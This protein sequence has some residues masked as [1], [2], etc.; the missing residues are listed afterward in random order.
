MQVLVTGGAGFIGSHLVEALLQRGDKVHVLD[1]LSTGKW[2]YLDGLPLEWIQ[3]DIEDWPTV[4]RAVQGCDLI[5]HLAALV[6]VP[7]SVAEPQLNHSVNVTGTFQIFEAARQAGLKR[8]VYASSAAVYGDA[9]VLPSTE[10]ISPRPITP[11]GLAKY[12]NEQY[13]AVYNHTYGTE[14][15][16]LRY[17]NVYGPRQDPGSPYSGVLTLF[18]QAVMTGK[19]VTVHGD[20]QQTRDF[21][22][23]MDVVSANLAAADVPWRAGMPAVFNVGSGKQTSLQ[24]ILEKIKLSYPLP[25]TYGPERAGD[26]RHSV[27]EVAL[28]KQWL[29]FVPEVALTTGLQKTVDWFGSFLKK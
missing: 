3:G 29:N 14:F 2:E 16:G 1:N 13:A 9:P 15:I 24:Q 10:S 22:Y 18:C 12:L 7:R 21:V 23:V 28:A 20:G 5:F 17:F 6:S 26:I 4:Q 11:Y 19:G 27:A 8:L 25:V